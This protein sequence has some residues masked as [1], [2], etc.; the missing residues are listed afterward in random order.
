MNN[1]LLNATAALVLVTLIGWLL[2]VGS[3]MLIPFVIA[4]IVWYMIDTLARGLQ[5]LPLAGGRLSRRLSLP[6]WI[7]L[8][9]ALV[10]IVSASVFFI[11]MVTANVAR[12]ASD[13]PAYQ[14]RLEELAASLSHTVG[15]EKTIDFRELLPDDIL[16]RF[17]SAAAAAVTTIAGSASLMFIYVLFLLIEQTTFDRKLA[18]LFADRAQLDLATAMRS[19]IAGRVRHY[20]GIKT[21]VSITTG[22][23][24]SAIL[25][26]AGLPYPALF[27]FIAFLLNYIP[28]IGS[29]I[30][31]IFPSLLALVFFDTLGPFVAIAI[32]L[33]IVQFTIGSLIEPR[34]MG[35]SLNISPLVIMLMLAFWGTVWGVTGMV[36]CVPLTV[37]IIIVCAQFPASRPIAVLLSAD[38]NVGQPVV[39]HAAGERHTQEKS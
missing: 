1:P 19:E 9:L 31:V 34:L 14:A 23:V 27:G 26:A 7:A 35:T 36:L 10:I 20:V 37:I 18:A 28:T 30:A 11:N 22:L 25:V 38:G 13:A 15:L 32:G 17:V 16:S 12:L 29:L 5:A 2:V 6:R 21:A 39:R 3:S 24:T 8:P 4:L 33:S